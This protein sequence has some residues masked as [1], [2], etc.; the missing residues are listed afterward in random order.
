LAEI[1]RTTGFAPSCLPKSKLAQDV[2][3]ADLHQVFP[4]QGTWFAP[5]ELRIAPGE[6]ALQDRLFEYIAFAEDFNRQ[7]AEG[8]DRRIR[9]GGIRGTLST[10]IPDL[11]R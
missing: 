2:L 4:Q 7:I 10:I 1:Q 8:Q 11:L 3:V 5:Y 6:G 9:S